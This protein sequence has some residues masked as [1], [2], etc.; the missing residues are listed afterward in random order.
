MWGEQDTLKAFAFNGTRFNET[1]VSESTFKAPPGMPGGFLSISASGSV[2]GTGIVWTALPALRDAENDVV[3]GVLRAFDASDLSHELWNSRSNAARDDLGNF[4]KHFPPTIANG[5]VYVASFSNQ[6]NVYGLLTAPTG[7]TLSVVSS[8][9]GASVVG[10]AV[11]FSVTV[12]GNVPTGTITCTD[13]GSR[14]AEA[15]VLTNGGASCTDSAL[16]IGTHIIAVTYQSDVNSAPVTRSITQT[17]SAAGGGGGASGG[18]E[19]GQQ[20]AV[21][22]AA[23]QA[24][25]VA[26]LSPA[27]AE[28]ADVPSTPPGPS[29]GRCFC[30][31]SLPACVWEA[32]RPRLHHCSLP[33]PD[34]VSGGRFA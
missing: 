24:E 1:P 33:R 13:N 5:H 7:T 9:A 22:L 11:T 28:A 15:V 10:K 14:F 26:Y 27:A 4:A 8:T 31:W 2:A 12:S 16:S 32:E 30:S 17:V 6:L 19:V 34:A 20:E 29:T 21:R 3:S 25:P 18:A 23:A